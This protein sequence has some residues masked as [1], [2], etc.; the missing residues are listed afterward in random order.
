MVGPAP[1]EALRLCQGAW[2]SLPASRV[3]GGVSTRQAGFVR[4]H[5]EGHAGEETALTFWFLSHWLWVCENRQVDGCS[6]EQVGRGQ[7]DSCCGSRTIRPS[8]GVHV[9]FRL[10]VSLCLQSW[11]GLHSLEMFPYPHGWWALDLCHLWSKKE[12]KDVNMPRN[13]T[14]ES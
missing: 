12:Q 3:D 9:G 6:L 14:V 13:T 1:T 10:P 7:K 11:M 8:Q 5:P 2:A 4:N